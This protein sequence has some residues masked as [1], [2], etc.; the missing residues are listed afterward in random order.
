MNISNL[1][2]FAKDTDAEAALM[3]YNYQTLKTLETWVYNF[4]HNINEDIYC[5]YE[6]DI[7]Q[8]HISLPQVKFRQIKLYADR[9]FS[10]AS[11][12]IAKCISHFFM[13]YI[14][15]NYTEITKSFVFETNANIARQHTTNDADLLKEWFEN[16]SNHSDNL[17]EKYGIKIKGIVSG[18][19]EKQKNKQL[20]LIDKDKN[21]NEEDKNIKKEELEKA[22]Q[23]LE[24]IDWKDFV[25]CINWNFV[26][27][28]KDLEYNDTKENIKKMLLQ[29][30]FPI[31]KEKIEAFLGILLSNVFDSVTQKGENKKLSR[32]KF[33]QL[34]LSNSNEKLDKWYIDT[35][36]KWLSVEQITNFHLGSFL[37]LID[38]VKYC[39]QN[40]YLKNHDTF[41]IN[42]LDQYINTPTIDNY[43]KRKAI[44]EYLC[45]KLRVDYE[46]F[47]ASGN[48]DNCENLISFYFKDFSNFR[49]ADELSNVLVVIFLMK[50][51]F[52]NE[53]I[54]VLEH[55]LIK[56]TNERILIENSTDELC[57]L[58]ETL[59]FYYLQHREITKS[60]EFFQKIITN[61]PSTIYYSVIDLYEKTKQLNSLYIK[62][63]IEVA[64]KI[65]TILS[66]LRKLVTQKQS[67]FNEAKELIENGVNYLNERQNEI[68]LDYFHQAL[69]FAKKVNDTKY[70][71]LALVNIAQLYVTLKM[72][73]AAKYYAFSAYWLYFCI[74]QEEYYKQI[75]DSLAIIFH[76]D[77]MQGAWF[78]AILDFDM[79]LQ[80]YSIFKS[81][82][83]LED[84]TFRIP[85]IELAIIFNQTPK[86]DGQFH[87]F[88]KFKVDD[89]G[90]IKNILNPM[91]EVL[92][93]QQLNLDTKLA[94]KPLNDV[95]K[96]RVIKFSC[97]NCSWSISFKNDYL[98]NSIAEEFCATIQI[99][100]M[101]IQLSE[102]DF[103][104]Q[105]SEININVE[106]NNSSKISTYKQLKNNTWE[107][108][109]PFTDSTK[110]EELKPHS[111]SQ[112]ITIRN[113][114]MSITSL[115]HEKFKTIFRK[116]YSERD[117]GN[118]SLLTN[119][120]QKIYRNIFSKEHFDSL[121]REHFLI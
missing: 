80:H 38:T 67:F 91:I 106:I 68:A 72:N 15:P 118:K 75:G 119:V 39:R 57:M 28:D 7:F 69:S 4:L 64:K 62:V 19:V 22:S 41:W 88:I 73:F 111:L 13:L 2:I 103:A 37:E 46:T 85:F 45:I 120:Y 77:Y 108:Y 100:L 92:N 53:T 10:F 40:N 109:I 47:E 30:S 97:L 42:L 33:E 76:A 31:E 9:P 84:E 93:N 6:E 86:I 32:L 110:Q 17:L 12:E 8:Q 55:G 102:D 104:L 113:I 44:Y 70:L 54:K 98:S 5:D 24:N 59:A 82:L 16:Q 63:D 117:L 51:L 49:N 48:L 11:E 95:G 25:K 121:Q 81:E 36:T 27:K 21:I 3:G 56:T 101:E 99:I 105:S 114:L 52:G 34:L 112:A 79:F 58:Y 74:N 18:Y 83:L 94:D 50:P 90:E 35:Y 96:F 87:H 89:L 23:Q 107:V 20:K 116:L 66:Q 115:S 43:F 61:I 78:S 60:I 26:N 14:K 29:I 65:G 71:Y 1:F